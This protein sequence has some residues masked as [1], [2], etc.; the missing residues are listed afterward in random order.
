MNDRDA[1]TRDLWRRALALSGDR[2]AA[3]AAVIEALR[4]RRDLRAVAAFRVNRLIV[5]GARQWSRSAGIVAAADGA[6][7]SAI[8][9]ESALQLWAGACA[10]E[11]QAF[12]SFVLL[13][14]QGLELIEAARA[15]DCSRTA[16]IRF[17]E[18]ARSQLD[19]L[20]GDAMPAALDSLRAAIVTADPEPSMATIECAQRRLVVRRRLV[21][22]TQLFILAACMAVLIWVGIDLLRANDH[23]R[24]T[25]VL[26]ESLSLPMSPEDSARARTEANRQKPA[27]DTPPVPQKESRP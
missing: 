20:L 12:E 14:V 13:D 21:A 10:L 24:N 6:L 4:S 1:I 5:Q 23:E 27:A 16:L 17:R 18:A 26:E 7:A 9:D 19:P 3:D 8:A 25:R 2:A 22:A 15:M 11:R